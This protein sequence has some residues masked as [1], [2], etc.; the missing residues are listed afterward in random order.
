MSVH[1]GVTTYKDVCRHYT[2]L[3]DAGVM[4]PGEQLPT[5]K[6]LEELHG[7]SHATAGKVYFVLRA[8]GYTYSTSRGTY[9]AGTR[10]E[11]LLERLRDA[12]NALDGDDQGLQL[13][14][15]DHGS[16]VMGRDG[17]VCWNSETRQWEIV[18]DA[19]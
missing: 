18:S 10:Q 14:V 4:R 3:I 1:Q 13:E 17:G 11:R 9:V 6:E 16:C 15:G 12:L 5:T 19:Q 2:S 7:I 8:Q